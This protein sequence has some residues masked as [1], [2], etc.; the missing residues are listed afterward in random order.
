LAVVAAVAAAVVPAAP[1]LAAELEELVLL[2]LLPQ[3][4]ASALTSSTPIVTAV[5]LARMCRLL[6]D[7]P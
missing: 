2:E 7:G 4:A 1:V 5:V 3:P 6:R